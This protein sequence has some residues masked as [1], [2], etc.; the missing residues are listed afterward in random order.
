MKI[1]VTRDDL[2]DKQGFYKSANAIMKNCGGAITVLSGNV[3]EYT[4]PPDMLPEFNRILCK[5]NKSKK[6]KD[7]N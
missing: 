5:Y 6:K 7:E 3:I 1:T 4:I 2:I